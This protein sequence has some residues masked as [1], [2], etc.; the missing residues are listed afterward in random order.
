M[1]EQCP[2][3]VAESKRNGFMTEA[4]ARNALASLERTAA[5]VEAGRLS[6]DWSKFAQQ[7]RE[8]DPYIR[9]VRSAQRA[10]QQQ[11][12]QQMNAPRAYQP[13][14]QQSDEEARFYGRQG[15]TL[16]GGRNNALLNAAWQA[17]QR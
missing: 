17:G 13:Q 1:R 2:R 3:L 10:Y 14:Q 11:Q 4:Q 16:Q 6:Q 8:V 7:G 5:E 15:Y 9:T 12:Q